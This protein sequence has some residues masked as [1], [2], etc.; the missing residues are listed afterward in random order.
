MDNLWSLFYY[1][2]LGEHH[3]FVIV[4]LNNFVCYGLFRLI[5]YLV[6]R[7]HRHLRSAS[8]SS[9]SSSLGSAAPSEQTRARSHM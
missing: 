7:V 5:I 8:Q 9:L 6:R 2:F 3:A 1:M 4:I